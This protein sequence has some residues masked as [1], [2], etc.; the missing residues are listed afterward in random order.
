[1]RDKV[2]A[3]ARVPTAV[4]YTEN[5]SAGHPTAAPLSFFF[6]KL[7]VM[8]VIN[9]GC[10]DPESAQQCHDIPANTFAADCREKEHP[11]WL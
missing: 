2:L 8:A 9:G 1:M 11:Q 5:H 3:S 4:R 7:S 6:G 10:H